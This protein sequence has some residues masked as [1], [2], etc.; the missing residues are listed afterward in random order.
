MLQTAVSTSEPAYAP[1]AP[2]T[3]GEVYARII[4]A[5]GSSDQKLVVEILNMM[6]QGQDAKAIATELGAGTS[7]VQTIVNEICKTLQ[8]ENPP[9]LLA[10]LKEQKPAD[11]DQKAN[12]FSSTKISPDVREALDE[13]EI[14][15]LELIMQGSK[16][17]DLP[18]KLGIPRD[19]IQ[20]ITGNIYEAYGVTNVSQ[21]RKELMKAS[22][23]IVAAPI[24]STQNIPLTFGRAALV[25]NSLTPDEQTVFKLA[26]QGQTEI[27]I[28]AGLRQKFMNASYIDKIQ[29]DLRRKLKVRDLGELKNVVGLA[30]VLATISPEAAVQ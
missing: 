11:N 20:G 5:A 1:P 27:E 18:G 13:L 26:A 8:V 10:R 23:G 4:Q 24:R 12:T 9:A 15:C 3:L 7:L 16:I 14:R 6:M 22:A 21:L 19:R 25:Y 30:Q 29:A 2:R 17:E 28:K